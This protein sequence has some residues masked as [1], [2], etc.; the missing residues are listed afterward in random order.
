MKQYVVCITLKTTGSRRNQIPH[1]I[2]PLIT[3]CPALFLRI[4][5]PAFYLLSLPHPALLLFTHSTIVL[6]CDPASSPP[7]DSLQCITVLGVNASM[8]WRKPYTANILYQ[9]APM[10]GDIVCFLSK[11]TILPVPISIF[12]PYDI[13]RRNSIKSYSSDLRPIIY[14]III[15][16]S[17]S[18]HSL[19][20]EIKCIFYLTTTTL[21][22]AILNNLKYLTSNFHQQICT[23]E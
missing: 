2:L 23:E 17:F 16:I 6:A 20:Q 14:W 13:P 3:R 9:M 12:H 7:L 15:S 21:P 5:Y 8:T 4:F 11:H 22:S 1:F 10:K 18:K 19:K